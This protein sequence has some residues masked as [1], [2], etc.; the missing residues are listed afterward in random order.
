VVQDVAQ[1]PSE[2]LAEAGEMIHALLGH[3]ETSEQRAM[4]EMKALSQVP[5][6]S[7][8]LEQGGRLVRR[9]FVRSDG[10]ACIP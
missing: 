3:A 4:H 1:K 2:I 10:C 5:W 8:G 7:L 9:P 6:V